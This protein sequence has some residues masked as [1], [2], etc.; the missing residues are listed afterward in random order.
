MRILVITTIQRN[1][2][3]FEMPPAPLQLALQAG[4]VAQS[5]GNACAK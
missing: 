2:A 1:Q 4:A 5:P 3:N